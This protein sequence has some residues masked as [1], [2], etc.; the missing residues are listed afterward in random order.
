[1]KLIN[2][3]HLSDKIVVRF[4]V[5]FILFFSSSFCFGNSIKNTKNK[6]ALIV[7]TDLEVKK[8]DTLNVLDDFEEK[9]GEIK[10][11]KVKNDKAI[12]LLTQGK[13]KKGWSVSMDSEIE[14]EIIFNPKSEA[15]GKGL[16]GFLSAPTTLHRFRARTSLIGGIGSSAPFNKVGGSLGLVGAYSLTPYF[17]P[18]VS[19]SFGGGIGDSA[20]NQSITGLVGME[21]LWKFVKVSANFLISGSATSFKSDHIKGI[22]FGLTGFGSIKNADF[23]FGI[24][25]GKVSNI[26]V[27]SLSSGVKIWFFNHMFLSPSFSYA[28]ADEKDSLGANIS[29]GVAL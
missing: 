22:G 12:A 28:V 2:V 25:Y 17:T 27:V 6:K 23:Y 16:D 29:L 3:T 4:L 14:E 11:L 5:P 26:S 1:M 19:T 13:M 9:V 8:G 21:F 10:V 20:S 7:L 15:V 18:Y 24:S